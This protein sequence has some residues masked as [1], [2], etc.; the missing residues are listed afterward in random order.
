MSIQKDTMDKG[1]TRPAKQ[2]LE[3]EQADT[4]VSG[5]RQGVEL[6][7]LEIADDPDSGGDPYNR[8]GQFCIIEIQDDD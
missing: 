4:D 1:S 7:S 6:V 5:L 3:A 8:T 2:G